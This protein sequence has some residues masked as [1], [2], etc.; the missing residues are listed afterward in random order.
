MT[1]PQFVTTFA[2]ICNRTKLP[3]FVIHIYFCYRVLLLLLY[4][5]CDLGWGYL[6]HRVTWLIDHLITWYSKK[7]L[8]P[9]PLT[10]ATWNLVN[11]EKTSEISPI[12]DESLASYLKSDFHLS[13]KIV[14]FAWWKPFKIDEKCFLFRL[15]S[16]FR[17]QNI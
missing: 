9:P 6:T 4:N 15:K 11:L 13:K 5:L 1:L 12:K 14:L 2:L 17:S 8:S 16:S 3:Q 10:M 7:V